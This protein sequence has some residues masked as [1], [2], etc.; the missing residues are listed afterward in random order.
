[1]DKFLIIFIV[2]LSYVLLL[3]I[4]RNLG[5]GSKKTCNNCNNCCPD[6]NLALNRIKRLYKDKIIYHIALKMFNHKRY[7]C[8]ECGWEGLRWEKKYRPIKKKNN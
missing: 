6:C 2:A 5:L 3:F 4:I 7:I 1:M 8:N